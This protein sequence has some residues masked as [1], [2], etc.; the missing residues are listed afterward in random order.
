MT[1]DHPD[2]DVICIT[3]YWLQEDSFEYLNL[4]N[5]RLEF[6]FCR[7]IKK[8]GGSR[9]F[10]RS[11]LQA[12]PYTKFVNNSC[13]E[14]YEASMVELTQ[15]NTIIICIYRTPASNIQIFINNLDITLQEILKINNKKV[16]ILGDFNINF[17]NSNIDPNLDRK[18]VV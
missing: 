16:I 13:E 3:E 17:L 6:K 9:I 10:V 5:F 2:L 18:S 4:K 1:A 15:L 12:K 11:T 14:H 8:H 7:K